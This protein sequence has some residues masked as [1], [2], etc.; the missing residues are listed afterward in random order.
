MIDNKPIVRPW[1]AWEYDIDSVD[2]TEFMFNH[3]YSGCVVFRF[4]DTMLSNGKVLLNGKEYNKWTLTKFIFGEESILVV[5]VVPNN[6]I[7]TD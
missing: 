6:E 7:P 1:A 2:S 5:Y 3:L 4:N